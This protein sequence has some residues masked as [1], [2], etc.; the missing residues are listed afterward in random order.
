MD[1]GARSR[2]PFVAY[3]GVSPRRGQGSLVA[4]FFFFF[5]S[6]F[7]VQCQIQRPR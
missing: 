7:Y 3:G 2:R 4:S 1:R 5:F 6:S